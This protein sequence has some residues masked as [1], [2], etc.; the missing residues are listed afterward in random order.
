MVYT[1]SLE[2]QSFLSNLH[3]R[4]GANQPP[5][6]IILS[7]DDFVNPKH[8]WVTY[9]QGFPKSGNKYFYILHVKAKQGEIGPIQ[10][11]TPSLYYSHTYLFSPEK[12]AVSLCLILDLQLLKTPLCK[13][14]GVKKLLD[15]A[16]K[17]PWLQARRQQ[18]PALKSCLEL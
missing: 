8:Y 14:L 11:S 4:E 10:C 15:F 1:G 13:N 6:N 7:E 16:G 9:D 12:R 5:P 17:C 3:H 2:L 18:L